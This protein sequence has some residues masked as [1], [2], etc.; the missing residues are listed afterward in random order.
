MASHLGSNRSF[1]GWG[2]LLLRNTN[3]LAGLGSGGSRLLRT[4]L[5]A[6]ICC[7]SL[8][9]SCSRIGD[10]RE[11]SGS[12]VAYGLTLAELDLSDAL[13]CGSDSNSRRVY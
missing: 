11:D 13:S 8:L 7:S 5:G 6:S 10:G 9:G 4:P 3:W 2:G 1:L 12:R